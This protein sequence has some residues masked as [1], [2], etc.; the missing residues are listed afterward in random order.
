[1]RHVPYVN[2]AAKFAAER[3]RLMPAIAGVFERGDFVGGAAIE[4]LESRLASA[5]AIVVAGARPIF[6]DVRPD[7]NIDPAAV[8]AAITSRTRAM[9]AS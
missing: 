1:M 9:A 4:E 2:F 7:L 8:A 6:A 3:E 5:G